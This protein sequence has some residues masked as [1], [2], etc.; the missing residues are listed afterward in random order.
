MF[1]TP[2]FTFAFFAPWREANLAFFT[3]L[4]ETTMTENEK[5]LQKPVP[6][7]GMGFFVMGGLK[8][9]VSRILF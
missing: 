8:P 4:P 3:P 7:A 5:A 1:L 2:K 9:V 6:K